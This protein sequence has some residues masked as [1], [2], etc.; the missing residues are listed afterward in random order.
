MGK[1]YTVTSNYGATGEGIT[2]MV[3]ITRAYPFGDNC[4]DISK[5][6]AY[7]ALK[8]FENVFGPF[9]AVM[10]DVREGLVF[11]F[12]GADLLISEKMRET[13]FL[14][15]KDAGGLEYHAK[16]NVNFG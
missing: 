6:R 16:I 1:I 14:W 12:S 3:L 9:Y 11:N 7:W 2:H 4:Y 5:D 13:L 15:E 8:N 10:A